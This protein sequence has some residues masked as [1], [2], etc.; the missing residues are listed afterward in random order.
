MEIRGLLVFDYQ[1]VM[2][3]KPIDVSFL[4]NQYLLFD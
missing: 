2:L 1:G 3:K 4:E